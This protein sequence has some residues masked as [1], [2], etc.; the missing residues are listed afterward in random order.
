ME[1]EKKNQMAQL[2][3][4]FNL[5]AMQAYSFD[6][7]SFDFDFGKIDEKKHEEIISSAEKQEKE[8]ELEKEK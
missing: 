3:K 7:V 1:P 5:E 8:E 4:K 2:S 6:N